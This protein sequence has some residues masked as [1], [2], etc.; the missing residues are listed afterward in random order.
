MFFQKVSIGQNIIIFI[1]QDILGEFTF[2]EN[3]QFA[4]SF[5]LALMDLWIKFHDK[6]SHYS[7]KIGYTFLN[8]SMFFLCISDTSSFKELQEFFF[9]S[10][11]DLP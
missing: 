10:L 3:L 11:C 8:I 2:C 4:A 6:S 7:S 5:V 9:F 1:D